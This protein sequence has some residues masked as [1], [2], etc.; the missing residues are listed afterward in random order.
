MAFVVVNGVEYT[1]GPENNRKKFKL[2][3][4]LQK[5]VG[6]LVSGGMDSAVLYW[7][8]VSLNH[9]AGHTHIIQPYTIYRTEGSPH[10]APLVIDYV[11][12]SWNIN[13]NAIIVGDNT[14]PQKMQ[15]ESGI[16]EIL[17]KRLSQVVYLGN[18]TMRQEHAIGWTVPCIRD[19]TTARSPMLNL[20]K[21][22]IVDLIVQLNCKELFTI[23]HS[24]IY[25]VGHCGQCNGCMERKWGFDQLKLIDPAMP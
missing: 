12:R 18:I 11:N 2:Q 16:K 19:M 7:L 23:S 10:Y 8:L 1:L 9:H 6:V 5:N 25:S 17:N 3:L 14:L 24:C 21:S 13:A 4:P 20:D 15:V 22:H